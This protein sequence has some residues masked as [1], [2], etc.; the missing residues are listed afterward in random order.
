VVNAGVTNV[1]LVFQ[2]DKLFLGADVADRS[3]V[4]FAGDDMFDGVSLN[5]TIPVD[6]LRDLTAHFLPNRR[7]GFAVNAAGPMLLWD[8]VDWSSAISYAVALKP[9]STIDNNDD[10]DQGYTVE[11]SFDLSKM[12]YSAGQQNKTV[13]IG[14]CS[15]DY[16]IVPTGT[17]GTR[18]WWFREWP[19]SASPAFCVLD[20]SALVVG[21]EDNPADANPLEFKL[22]GVYPNPFNPSTTFRFDLPE[23]GQARI[24]LFD[25][26]G[27]LVRQM[28]LGRLQRGSHEQLLDASSLA[29][30][31]YYGRIEFS[32]D[33]TGIRNLSRSVRLMLV[34]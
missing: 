27:R 9:G 3:I 15:H 5:M 25:V 32:A 14:V 28:D 29:S 34:K 26:L 12:G 6:S 20:N 23:A 7:F 11:A 4:S 1:K 24:V 30:G 10:V 31:A 8:G 18:A 33:R 21:V 2:G 13:A 16:D 22:H 19:G 17:P